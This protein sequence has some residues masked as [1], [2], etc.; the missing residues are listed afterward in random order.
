MHQRAA[1]PRATARMTAAIVALSGALVAGG[2]A[3]EPT[4]N[5]DGEKVE[6]DIGGNQ[7]DAGVGNDTG[8]VGPVD[9]GIVDRV[10]TGSDQPDVKIS[11]KDTGPTCPGEP[12]C[13]CSEAKDCD[14]GFCIETPVGFRCAQKCVDS[15][16][17]GF[18]CTQASGGGG[19]DTSNIC[20]PRWGRICD[21][22]KAN[23]DCTAAGNLDAVCVDRGD[24]GAYCGSKCSKTADCPK[25]Y[26]CSDVKDVNGKDHKQCVAQGAACGCSARAISKELSTKCFITAGDGKC[27]G[28][29][30]CLPDG[31]PGAPKGGGLTACVA[32]KA[33]PE[34]CD[35]KDN[36]CDG[37]TDE[38]TCDDNN[39]CTA[40]SCGGDKGCKHVNQDG[41][42]DADGS[43]CTSGDKCK[44]GKCAAGPA[45]KCDDAN[46]C[47]TDSCDPKKGCQHAS[48][49]GGVCNADDNPCTVGDKCDG[50]VCS[51]GKLKTCNSGDQCIKGKCN[52][53]TGKC[54]YT[55]QVA[56]P[57]DDG[58]PCTTG[59]ICDNDGCKA[60]KK[61]DCDDKNTC[62][63][64]SCDIKSGCNHKATPNACDDGDKCTKNDACA[65]L[66]CVGLAVNVTDTCGDGNPCTLNS[67][68]AAKGC[69]VKKLHNKPC[70][71]GNPCSAPD[72][73]QQGKCVAGSNICAC[74]SNA[75]CA[76]KE[77]GNLCNGTLICDKTKAPFGCKVDPASVVKC[78][79][80]L[81]SACQSMDCDASNGKCVLDKKA[82]GTPCDADN[83]V[84][85]SQDSC[86]D[87]K[88]AAGKTLTC[89]DSNVCTT[90][91][92]DPKNGCVYKPNTSFCD[93]DGDKCTQADTCS[94]GICNA[95]KKRVCKDANACTADLCDKKT[96]FC[97]FQALTVACDDG[98]ACTKGEACHKHKDTGLPVCGKG[99][100]VVCDDNNP[101]TKD[102]CDAKLGCTNVAAP[103]GT[104]CSDNNK[105]TAADSCN[106]GLCAG[107][108][109]NVPAKCDD[110]NPCTKDSC[111]AVAGCQHAPLS[112]IK[113]DDG[114]VCTAG[115]VCSSG[116]CVSGTNTCACKVDKDCLAK[117]DGNPCNGTLFCDTSKAP[118]QCKTNPK[119]IV[120][121]DAS[122]DGFCQKNTCNAATGKCAYITKKDATPCN[123]DDSICT[124]ADACDSGLCKAGKAL[125]CND[126]N[127]CTADSCDPKK[128]CQHTPQGGQCEA[129]GNKC[130]G[131]D[132]CKSGT[133]IVG[134]KKGCDDNNAC[135]AD[136]CD[137]KKGDCL[138]NNLAQS[139]DDGD[140]CT[141]GDTCGKD[142]AGKH[143]CLSGKKVDCNDGNKC[144]ND[145][146]DSKKGCTNALDTKT[147]HACYGGPA[148]T[149]GKGTC[150]DGQA[151]CKSDGTLGPC[152][153]ATLPVKKEA[154]D[155]KDDDCDGTTDEGCA[156][157]QFRARVG[158]AVLTGTSGKLGVRAFAG[159]SVASGVT[160][161]AAGGKLGA[162]F[163]FYEWLGRW[164]GK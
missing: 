43:Q 61:T 15:C 86:Q 134:G 24:I 9:T 4:E 63:A 31:A 7:L 75:D 123:A 77:D 133:C 161:P 99:K 3:G 78:D 36:D 42:C 125:Q 79:K 109:I 126:N 141:K 156:P 11:D 64:D 102:V 67:C 39:V 145:S 111:D 34:A 59:E 89:D 74:K 58:N 144:T 160:K 142:K 45:L 1:D 52:L 132:L 88:C 162:G 48:S 127:P 105:C 65:G 25:G 32:P 121:C 112:N 152:L 147:A 100:P 128:G 51:A 153:G 76:K 8:T 116:K 91:S 149:R 81:N 157:T 146:C 35:G 21:P 12:G 29:R 87:G 155:S 6:A 163:G 96:G 93:A 154:C 103:A 107:K 98:D 55:P 47:T 10:D 60:T 41:A 46:E 108:P 5:V 106:S 54:K 82:K 164:L 143:V 114:N 150:K 122:K 27:P 38:T 72:S 84:C 30:T 115:D 124:V 22:C 159:G 57:C 139:C 92:C 117:E 113:C 2:C 33:T 131:P 135:T 28:K 16:P 140:A 71:D 118:F 66:K 85:T 20:V 83:S 104:P 148:A 26:A 23:A 53:L 151:Q 49:S 94:A 50:G 62:T 90:D 68:D 80:S 137:T 17:I 136:S 101:C 95:G 158:N 73:C 69:V 97:N 138:Y 44:D 19:G 70:D 56:L 129:D 37:Q 13:E 110:N 120:K 40:D 130:T 119:T 18:K 14:N